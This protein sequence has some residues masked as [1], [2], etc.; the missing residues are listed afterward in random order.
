MKK[1][2]MVLF[3]LLLP[4]VMGAPLPYE[5][6]GHDGGC[7]GI[8]PIDPVEEPLPVVPVVTTVVEPVRRVFVEGVSTKKTWLLDERHSTRCVKTYYYM[9]YQVSKDGRMNV[10][11]YDGHDYPMR[12]KYEVR[13]LTV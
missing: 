6:D 10:K 8:S 9:T 3:V 5:Q 1:S 7:G 4:F 13:C 12:K 2:I 11:V